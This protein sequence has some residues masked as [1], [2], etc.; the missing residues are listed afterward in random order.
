ME[1]Y[2]NDYTAT[3][4]RLLW[5][6]HEIRHALHQEFKEKTLEQ[7]NADGLKT[8]QEWKKQ[9]NHKNDPGAR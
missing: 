3:E 7:I 4:D 6:L 1:T 8:Y 9:R 5:E 2:K